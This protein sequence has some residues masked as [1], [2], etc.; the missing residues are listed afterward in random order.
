MLLLSQFI[1]RNSIIIDYPFVYVDVRKLRHRFRP[2]HRQISLKRTELFK[3]YKKLDHKLN[4][5]Y[6]QQHYKGIV[7][8]VA[9]SSLVPCNI[10]FHL[11]PHF[12]LKKKKRKKE[13]KKETKKKKF[14]SN[15]RLI[16]LKCFQ[17]NSNHNKRNNYVQITF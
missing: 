11:N 16:N 9:S 1:K 14:D 6:V 12:F 17:L 10:I 2:L 15:N 4:S 3:G 13:R 7:L 5:V 8:T